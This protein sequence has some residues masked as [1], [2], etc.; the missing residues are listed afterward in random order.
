MSLSEEVDI[1]IVNADSRQ[2]YRWMDIGTAKP[3]RKDLERV[4]HH[5]ID[6]VDPDESFSAGEFSRLAAE[7]VDSVF[8]SGSTP[9][10]V[11]GSGLYIMAFTG[12][13]DDLP[14]RNDLLRSVLRTLED[15]DNGFLHRFLS[16]VDPE[17]A[18]ET[19][20]ADVMRLV[21]ALEI[22]LQSGKT[23]SLLR[24]GGLPRR[25]RFRIVTMEIDRTELRSRIRTR[26]ASMF[27]AGLVEEVRELV[28]HGYGRNSVLGNTIGYTEV[29]DYL[30]G[31]L[32]LDR[33]REAVE[34]NTW[35]LAR[36]QRNMFRRLKGT[37]LW[38]GRN[39]GRLRE[40]LLED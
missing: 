1:E 34:I 29:L 9:L 37:L 27:D 11:G 12:S 19:G 33:T 4:R 16:S 13:L 20:P 32:T 28:S 35:H 15:E 38:D 7:A 26:T 25:E 30:D 17:L 39:P 6:I 24:R 14:R 36:R 23:A 2:V 8:S 40:I 10:L 18:E 3:D 21:R 22:V 5:L 31:K